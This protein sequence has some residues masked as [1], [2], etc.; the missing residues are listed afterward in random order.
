MV[1]P[2]LKRLQKYY[3]GYNRKYFGNRLPDCKIKWTELHKAYGKDARGAVGYYHAVVFEIYNKG[4]WR[5]HRTEYWIELSPKI[6]TMGIFWQS[7]LIHEMAHLSVELSHPRATA[8]G[9]IWQKEMLRLA[10]IGA[11]KNLW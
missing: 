1:K 8:H 3:A 11:F 4:K 10:T 5:K 7:T 9:R 6:G 2:S